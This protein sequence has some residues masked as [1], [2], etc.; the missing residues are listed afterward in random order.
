M[1]EIVVS[2]GVAVAVSV[3]VSVPVSIGVP[4]ERVGCEDGLTGV[5]VSMDGG[6]KMAGGNGVR[7][8]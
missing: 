4:V 3:K 7:V 5:I 2:V 6:V 8:G 1:Y